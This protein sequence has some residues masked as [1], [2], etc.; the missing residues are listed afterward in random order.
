MTC[1]APQEAGFVRLLSTAVTGVFILLHGVPPSAAASPG[2]AA[3]FG[4]RFVVAGHSQATTSNEGVESKVHNKEA[5]TDGRDTERTHTHRIASRSRAAGQL[6][7]RQPDPESSSACGDPTNQSAPPLTTRNPPRTPRPKK[8]Y[9]YTVFSRQDSGRSLEPKW[10]E[11]KWLRTKG[12]RVQG[13]KGPR[14]QGSKGPRVQGSTGP[15]V[16]GSRGTRV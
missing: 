1:P 13:S 12:P 5:A 3:K 16:Q 8:I 4:H 11:P 9:L 15:R 2:I 14:V 7:T 10:L 6:M